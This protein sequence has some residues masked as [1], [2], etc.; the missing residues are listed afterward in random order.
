MSPDSSLLHGSVVDADEST[1][2]FAFPYWTRPH[3][4]RKHTG[5]SLQAGWGK[6]DTY[7]VGNDG[8]RNGMELQ[9]I[10]PR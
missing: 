8:M 2:N 4:S 1:Q 9:Q 10:A 5:Q 3:L 7:E 6:A